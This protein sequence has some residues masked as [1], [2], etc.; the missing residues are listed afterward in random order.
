MTYSVSKSLL[1][2]LQDQMYQQTY[3]V[4]IFSGT[5][6]VFILLV[7]CKCMCQTHTN[8]ILKHFHVHTFFFKYTRR[9]MEITQPADPEYVVVFPI[10][11]RLE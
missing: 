7:E 11:V 3:F 8:K 1:V 4:D 2:A 9:H 10:L 6:K 5:S